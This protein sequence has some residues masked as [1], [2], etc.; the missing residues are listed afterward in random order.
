MAVIKQTTL[1]SLLSRFLLFL[2]AGSVI[3]VVIPAALYFISVQTGMISNADTAR[4]DAETSINRI[5]RDQHF[6][7]AAISTV[8]SY[9]EL[10][11]SFSLTTSNMSRSDQEAVIAHIRDKKNT[12]F[13][14]EV[15]TLP[16]GYVAIAYSTVPRFTNAYLHQHFLKPDNLFILLVFINEIVVCIGCVLWFSAVL[17]RGLIPLSKAVGQI[18]DG[19]LDFDTEQSKIREFN[20]I[21]ES[22]NT[23]K[24]NL[25]RSLESQWK[26]E[27]RN[28]DHI[29]ALAHDIKTPLSS[30]SGW[31]QLLS[32]TDLS[33]EQ[34]KFVTNLHREEHAIECLTDNLITVA[35]RESSDEQPTM[36]SVPVTGFIGEV[37]A[38][39]Q[40]LADVRQIHMEVHLPEEE[41]ETTIDPSLA[42]QAVVNA[43]ANALRFTPEH[44]Q[45]VISAKATPALTVRV[46]D[47]GPGFTKQDLREATRVSYMADSSR[48]GRHFGLGLAVAKAN[49]ELHGGQ[50]ILGKSVQLGG[51]QVDMIFGSSSGKS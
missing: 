7:P 16:S 26:S 47:S 38:S 9:V 48:S 2:L 30:I 35:I 15:A 32:E 42:R 34:Y 33:P 14:L 8:N 1:R 4:K 10:D 25:R 17:S 46:E 45:V 40:G 6:D 23:L 19:N 51:A 12:D 31:T 11:Q 50:L 18:R 5:A 21:T 3:V 24:N 41:C 39:L 44:G 36:R 27:Q 37:T 43:I 28:R 49:V 20:E 22:V 13:P 29:S